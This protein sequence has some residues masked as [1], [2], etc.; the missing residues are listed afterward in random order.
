MLARA[1]EIADEVLFPAALAVDAAESVP[2]SH[3]DLLAAEGFYGLAARDDVAYAELAGVVEALAGGDLATCFVWIQHHTPVRALA[4]HATPALRDAFLPRLLAGERRAGI[5][6]AGIRTPTPL[7]VRPA[8][9]GYLLDGQ[10]PW[11]TGWGLVDTVYL[12]A[13]DADGV[14][15]FL[16]ADA[17]PADTVSAVT[18]RLVAVQASATVNLTYRDHPVPAD[19]LVYTLPYQE[20]SSGDAGGSATNGFLALG[21]TGRCA[22]LL[23]AAGRADAAAV[24]RAEAD[25]CRDD[26]L[27]A[28]PDTTPAARA[29]T[30]ELVWRAAGMLTA[31]TGARSVLR[32]NHA[33]RLAREATFLLVFGSRPAIRD[34]LLQKLTPRA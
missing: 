16:L 19:R 27:R 29:A 3:L 21:V 11:V 12:A 9:G 2:A 13:L 15:H 10:V 24:L 18:Q 8:D 28:G 33:Q 6:I 34:V 32:D 22:S 5:G 30:A 17:G 26:L 20:W 23:A 31:Q 4:E 25:A 1:H 7:R 14:V